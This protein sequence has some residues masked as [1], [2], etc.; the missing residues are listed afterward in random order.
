MILLAGKPALNL[1]TYCVTYPV[2]IDSGFG[3]LSDPIA[4]LSSL[5]PAW[6]LCRRCGRISI[7][8]LPLCM[9]LI[10]TSGISHRL[11]RTSPHYLSPP[12]LQFILRSPPHAPHGPKTCALYPFS[13]RGSV[14]PGPA[15]SLPRHPSSTATPWQS[16]QH[17]ATAD[18]PETNS[19]PTLC[20]SRDSQLGRFRSFKF[21]LPVSTATAPSGSVPSASQF[22]LPQQTDCHP[23]RQGPTYFEE[24]S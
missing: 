22:P 5:E 21:V 6:L 8:H 4:F 14:T 18:T 19:P 24:K 2:L 1:P 10:L 12:H 11:R 23:R 16:S 13:W 20:R 3:P 9:P 7:Y 15:T 17:R